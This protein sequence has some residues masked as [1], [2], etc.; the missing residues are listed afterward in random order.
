MRFGCNEFNDTVENH[1]EEEYIKHSSLDK[2]FVSV[3]NSKS[4]FCGLDSHGIL[5][6]YSGGD[7]PLTDNR[8]MFETNVTSFA[9]NSNNICLTKE[10]FRVYC[11]WGSKG[12]LELTLDSEYVFGSAIMA[13]KVCSV[14][15]IGITIVCKYAQS[16]I[17]AVYDISKMSFFFDSDLDGFPDST[18]FAP[19]NESSSVIC[20]MGSYGGLI[21]N[22][23]SPG[24]FVPISGLME[25]IACV[26]EPT[27]ELRCG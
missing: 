24:Y 5:S 14:E 6:C 10:D 26:L 25:Q 7:D 16:E 8:I 2:S 27:T 23:S 15:R 13:D 21:C 3:L 18:D 11:D 22:L 17:S 9:M 12:Q 20:P 19:H 4:S 1:F